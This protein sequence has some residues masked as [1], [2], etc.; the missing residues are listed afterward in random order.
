MLGVDGWKCKFKGKMTKHIGVA[1]SLTKK[2]GTDGAPHREKLYPIE[3][4]A[5]Y[6]FTGC[7]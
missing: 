1:F 2:N 3:S 4:S 5:S 6:R 7:F